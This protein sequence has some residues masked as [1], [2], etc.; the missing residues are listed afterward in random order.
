MTT[1][2]FSLTDKPSNSKGWARYSV[3]QGD[4]KVIESNTGNMWVSSSKE[5]QAEAGSEIVLTAQVMLRE[6]KYNK[7]TV[8]PEV[9]KLIV[10]DGATAEISFRPGSQGIM[11]KIEGARRA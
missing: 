2:K 1:V 9:T 4:R 6:G 7:E 8:Y 3:A 5:G 11:I 10:E